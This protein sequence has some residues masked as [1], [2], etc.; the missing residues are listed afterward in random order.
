M[1]AFHYIGRVSI[2]ITVI[3]NIKK[4]MNKNTEIYR[5]TFTLLYLFCSKS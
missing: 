5:N 3:Y 4:K 2:S 1:V